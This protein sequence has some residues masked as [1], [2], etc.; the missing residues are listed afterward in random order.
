MI[1]ASRVGLQLGM[2]F[3]DEPPFLDAEGA[4]AYCSALQFIHSKYPEMRI[5]A[6]SHDEN[7][8]SAFPQQITVDVTDQGSKVAQSNNQRPG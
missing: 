5:V 8:K 4:E 6:I 2:L 1:K 7:M 3:V